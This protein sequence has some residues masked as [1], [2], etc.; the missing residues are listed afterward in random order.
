MPRYLPLLALLACAAPPEVVTV[1]LTEA[2]TLDALRCEAH[3]VR[4]EG[5]VPHVYAHDRL[6]AAAVIG[7][8]YARDRW[9]TLDA[10]R[11]LSQGTL[12]ALLGDLALDS[13]IAARVEG[14]AHVA[15]Q[16]AAR[17]T[18][19]ER[20]WLQAYADG[21]NAYV[22]AVQAGDLPVASELVLA[23]PLVGA[24]APADLMEPF[25]AD[26]VAAVL[27]TLVFQL[28]WEPDDAARSLARD[29]VLAGTLASSDD[30]LAARHEAAHVA[31]LFRHDPLY[32]RV[33]APGWRAEPLRNA[34]TTGVPAAPPAS[35]PRPSGVPTSLLERAVRG[36][37]ASA[38]RLGRRP[39]QPRGSNAWAVQG[40]FTA[41][42]ATLLAGDGHL[43]LTV[44]SLFWQLGV[45]TAL[46][47]RRDDRDDT[48]D[49]ALTQVGLGLPG[50]PFIAVGTNGRVAWSQTRLRGDITDAFAEVVRLGDDGLPTER[51]TT[52][53]WEALVA[54]EEQFEVADVP[55]LGSVGRTETIAVFTT[56]D[57][58]RLVAVE[59]AEAEPDAPGVVWTTDGP[60]LPGDTDGDGLI[61]A[62]SLDFTGYDPTS[63]VAAVD[64]FG[65]ADDVAEFREATRFLNAYC[66]NMVAADA[67]GSV[68]Y[69]S[70]QAQPCRLAHRRTALGGWAPGHD[71]AYLLDGASLPGFEVRLDDAGR[72]DERAP[73]DPSRCVA[74]FEAVP[75]SRDPAQGWVAT[76]NEDPGGHAL[77]GN[78]ANERYYLGGPWDGGYRAARI[79]ERLDALVAAGEAD[80]EGMI[81]LQ[82]DQRAAFGILLAPY[83]LDALREARD[84]EP[85]VRD[86]WGLD[87]RFPEVL[88]RLAAW[89]DRGFRAPSGVTTVYETPAPGDADDAVATMIFNAWLGRFRAAVLDDEGLPD[90]LW[91]PNRSTGT[92]RLLRRMFE[93]R[94]GDGPYPLVRGEDGEESILF[95]VV[96]T[97]EVERSTTL[98][99]TALADALAFLSSPPVRDGVGGFGTDD[100]SAWLWGLRHQVRFDSI[101]AEFLGDDPVFGAL[102]R[103]FAIVPG[104]LPVGDGLDDLPGFPRGGDNGSVDAA[105][106]GFSTS[107]FS[108]GSGPAFRMVIALARRGARTE[109]RGVNVLP[110]GQS[111]LTDSPYF[112]DQAALWLG[113]D[114]LPLRFHLDDVI[115][116]ATGRELFLPA[117]GAC[118]AVE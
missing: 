84:G 13:D 47:Q 45:D 40:R 80:L 21:V 43:P 115:E 88:D 23:G 69:T 108:Y 8:T 78:T 101:L 6:D 77:D 116:G 104:V 76:A 49:R 73:T 27:A 79:G 11:R 64:G 9:F 111:A 48:P 18:V 72:V 7:F 16:L 98:A 4:T 118:G 42:G 24:D 110:G 86:L 68:L 55:V 46:L 114:A 36:F 107:D 3:V 57:G 67:D 56:A 92:V 65:T 37:D 99:L 41:D 74:P 66:Q 81:T 103:Q 106:W 85:R 31:D 90:A 30:P 26:D 29:T 14:Q 71:P 97:P 32:D 1:P 5:G 60:V 113:N 22:A 89:A 70:Y 15:R 102:T 12:A 28:G 58:R 50:L 53:G 34:G 112:A 52:D 91:Q 82:G 54:T 105:S 2:C 59:G 44:P 109:V 10:A 96:G 25:T 61:S 38:R 100:P 35:S 63:L 39:D 83:L 62:I 95:D 94:D 33:S 20:A 19:A 17:L 87:A 75:W 51:A 93:D 117:A